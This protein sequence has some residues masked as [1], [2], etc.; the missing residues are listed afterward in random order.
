MRQIS[1]LTQ[2]IADQSIRIIVGAGKSI[3]NLD[4]FKSVIKDELKAFLFGD[5]YKEE[6]ECIKAGTLSDKYI[7]A[8]II[9]SVIQK[10]IKI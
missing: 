8:S 5:Q 10:T 1:E 3:K 2:T 7:I 6:R 4:Q 9:A